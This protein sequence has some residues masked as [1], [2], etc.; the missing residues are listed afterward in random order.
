MKIFVEEVGKEVDVDSEMVASMADFIK[1]GQASVLIDVDPA[2]YGVPRIE[3]PRDKIAEAK[4]AGTMALAYQDEFQKLG[5]GLMK[6]V[7]GKVKGYMQ[8]RKRSRA[9]YA[10]VETKR[11]RKAA[12]SL[13]D[14]LGGVQQKKIAA[15][16]TSVPPMGYGHGEDGAPGVP[17]AIQARQMSVERAAEDVRQVGNPLSDYAQK[18]LARMQGTSGSEESTVRRTQH[19]VAS[20]QEY[21]EG[22]SKTAAVTSVGY[23]KYFKNKMH[24]RGIT[25]LAPLSVEQKKDFFQGVD[26]GWHSSQ[27]KAM[28]LR[29]A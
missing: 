16:G 15:L 4:I 17:E 6:G 1:E 29:K 28:K 24:T 20:I 9:A 12:A 18:M 13:A 11:T 3:I 25:S 19:K 26:K 2:R 8:R 10:G 7:L 27:E 22:L 23:S 14:T 21:A 5:A